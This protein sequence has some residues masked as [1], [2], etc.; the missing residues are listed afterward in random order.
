MQFPTL[1][2]IIKIE[3]DS[4]ESL[5]VVIFLCHNPFTGMLSHSSEGNPPSALKWD[6]TNM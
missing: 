4:S 2:K 6:Y 5:A 3:P 1:E